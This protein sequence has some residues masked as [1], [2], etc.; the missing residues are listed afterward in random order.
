VTKNFNKNNEID[1]LKKISEEIADKIRKQKT[2]KEIWEKELK[3]LWGEEIRS[4]LGERCIGVFGGYEESQN[5]WLK[6]EY[7]SK[8]LALIK[9]YKVLTGEG[10]FYPLN[11]AVAFNKFLMKPTPTITYSEDYAEWLVSLVPK[12][13]VFIGE[14]QT[15]AQVEEK[16]ALDLGIPTCGIRVIEKISNESNCHHLEV[17]QNQ[18]F[19]I[20]KPHPPFSLKELCE[21]GK[22]CPFKE[23]G[24]PI[25][26]LEH[27]YVKGCHLL[28]VKEKER[29]IAGLEYLGFI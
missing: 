21:K 10:V 20:C 6:I 15:T 4:F 5:G 22:Y 3:P 1:I 18:L 16:K 13:I 14:R 8:E 28:A 25:A 11:N 9:K 2:L 27:Y 24:R 26:R 19:S 7:L 12:V 29:I 17:N 23:K